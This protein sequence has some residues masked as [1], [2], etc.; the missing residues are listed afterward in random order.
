MSNPPRAHVP[1][2]PGVHLTLIQTIL[3]R[4][5]KRGRGGGAGEGRKRTEEGR[6]EG[7][8][9]RRGRK[10]TRLELCCRLAPGDA[11]EEHGMWVR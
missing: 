10:V 3:L 6:K 9:E 2:A 8:E 7:G 5:D 4:R 1:A 11:E